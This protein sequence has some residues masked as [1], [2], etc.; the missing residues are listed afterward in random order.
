[1]KGKYV[2]LNDQRTICQILDKIVI[3]DNTEYLAMTI[4]EA[5]ITIT[6]KQIYRLM[7]DTSTEESENNET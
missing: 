4:D 2:L 5:I 1:M 7:E 6:P 3:N